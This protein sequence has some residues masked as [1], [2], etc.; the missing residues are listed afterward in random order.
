MWTDVFAVKAVAE[1]CSFRQ[2]LE[3]KKK[4]TEKRESATVIHALITPVF[5]PHLVEFGRNTADQNQA[6]APGLKRFGPC[7]APVAG[8]F[9]QLPGQLI[10]PPPRVMLKSARAKNMQLAVA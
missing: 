9:T 5:F 10:L 6:A 4:K 7:V 8:H 2:N 3:G 1:S